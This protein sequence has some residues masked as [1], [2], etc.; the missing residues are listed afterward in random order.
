MLDLTNAK[1]ITV[2]GNGG[3][4]KTTLSR[5][6]GESLRLPVHHLDRI[7][8]L[9]GL[10]PAGAEAIRAELERIMAEPEWVIDGLGQLWTIEMRLPRADVIVFLDFPLAE[11]QEWGMRR[12]IESRGIV[13]PDM[14]DGT[15]TDGLDDRL[16]ELLAWVDREMVPTLRHW[17]NRPENVDRLI[18]LRSR[19]ELADLSTMLASRML[20][21]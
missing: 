3:T 17:M 1:R 21:P 9:P 7:Q 4:G 18:W 14:P 8:W 19:Q 6:I 11:C 12:Q 15:T 20:R 5:L 16:M 2:I 10:V 13:R